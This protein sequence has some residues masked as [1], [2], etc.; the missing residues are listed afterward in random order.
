MGF[1]EFT[2]GLLPI[3][4]S[5]LYQGN[6]LRSLISLTEEIQ[7][8]WPILHPDQIEMERA[9]P[10]LPD[11]QIILVAE[12]SDSLFQVYLRLGN[13]RS[14]DILMS[15]HFAYCNPRRVIEPVLGL[16][17]WLMATY[18]LYCRIEP[19]LPPEFQTKGDLIF[20][21]TGLHQIL[22][23][24]YDYNRRFWQLDFGSVEEMPLR[25]GDAVAH[26]LTPLVSNV[27]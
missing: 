8:K 26:F 20:N 27:S 21:A 14:D 22:L 11:N 12:Q 2:I 5:P 23:P 19:D 3:E 15:L 25:P 18:M 1:A 4:D 17:E 16:A 13:L 9:F 24:C 7:T 6:D 10:P